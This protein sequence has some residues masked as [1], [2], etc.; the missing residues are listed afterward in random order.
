MNYLEHEDKVKY[1]DGLLAREQEWQ[2]FVECIEKSFNLSDV[3]SWNE[4]LNRNKAIRDVYSYFV[5]VLE[6]C[7]K[8]W[9]VETEVLKEIIIVSKY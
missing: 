8:E 3:N 7:D 4:Y 9:T 1:I 5:K 2:W 6:V